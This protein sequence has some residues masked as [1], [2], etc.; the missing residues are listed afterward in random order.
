MSKI[1]KIYHWIWLNF[2][3]ESQ[4]DTPIP[5]KY[6]KTIDETKRLNPDWEFIEWNGRMIRELM[7]TRYPWFMPTFNSYK[8]PIQRAD[9]SRYF[10]LYTYG[11]I[12]TDLD[13]ICKKPLTPLL[14][15]YADK[16]CIITKENLGMGRPP[17]PTNSIIL[18][19]P[20]SD[21]MM[22][23]IGILPYAKAKYEDM[24]G[25]KSVFYTTGPQHIIH[26]LDSYAGRDSI[27]FLIEEVVN[28]T[29]TSKT[30][31]NFEY[32]INMNEGTWKEDYFVHKNQKLLIT[33]LILCLIFIAYYK[34]KK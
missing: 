13:S 24:P 15:K 8:K 12:Y 6:R 11:G 7:E 20:G 2:K 23:I 4:L 9:A 14:D 17:N 31:E 18:S 1:P 29:Q 5:V 21:F 30:L 25:M 32:F 3:D 16:D 19:K 34:L 10:I 27:G 22:Y 33:I 26:C 28:T